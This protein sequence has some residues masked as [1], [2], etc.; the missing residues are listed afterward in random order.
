MN[1]GKHTCIGSIQEHDSFFQFA[2]LF[3]DDK[4][5]SSE[6]ACQVNED[7]LAWTCLQI[8]DLYR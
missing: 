4:L 1:G 2:H 7:M 6:I 5:C 3:E 8:V